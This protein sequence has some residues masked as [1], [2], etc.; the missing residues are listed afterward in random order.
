MGNTNTWKARLQDAGNGSV[1]RI[2]ELPDEVMAVMGWGIG[3][4]LELVP[5]G[6]GEIRL[7]K[8]C[9]AEES[10]YSRHLG[11]TYALLLQLRE[12]T[13][14]RDANKLT[15]IAS[16][17]DWSAIAS[18]FETVAGRYRSAVFRHGRRIIRNLRR[19]YML[20]HDCTELAIQVDMLSS[21]IEDS[22]SLR[23]TAEKAL[24]EAYHAV[25]SRETLRGRPPQGA[26][27]ASPWPTLEALMEAAEDKRRR[28]HA[29]QAAAHTGYLNGQR[30][31]LE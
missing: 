11:V 25:L 29:L 27:A 3:D 9:P 6:K 4:E 17:I 5:S 1:D 8:V 7:R 21:A 15:E 12:V 14:E 28:G 10:D 16:S 30:V 13:A 26:P 23:A 20:Y 18:E 31:F 22:P 19:P 2:L 24:E